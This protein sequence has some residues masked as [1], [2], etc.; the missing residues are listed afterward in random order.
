MDPRRSQCAGYVKI[1]LIGGFS[2]KTSFFSGVKIGFFEKW[3]KNGQKWV[4]K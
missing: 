1:G 3:S 4:I 2:Q